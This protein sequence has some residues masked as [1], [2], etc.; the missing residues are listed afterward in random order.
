MRLSDP[1]VTVNTYGHLDIGDMRMVLDELADRTAP[2]H[3]PAAV[4]VASEL[5]FGA[6][7]SFGADLVTAHGADTET[8]LEASAIHADPQEKISGPSWIRTRDQSVM[9]RQL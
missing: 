9:S 4:D 7:G 1:R 8:A 6:T 2:P 3:E 5:S